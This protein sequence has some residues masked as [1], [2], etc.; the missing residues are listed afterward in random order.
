MYL[1]KLALISMISTGDRERRF[2]DGTLCISR[3]QMSFDSHVYLNYQNTEQYVC[4]LMVG[5]RTELYL[6]KP[7]L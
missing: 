3:M 1:S 4:V 2:N 7:L 5:G 6:F